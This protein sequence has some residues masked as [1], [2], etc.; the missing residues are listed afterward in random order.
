M[1]ADGYLVRRFPLIWR[2]RVTSRSF[3]LL[4]GVIYL[5]LGICG[6]IPGLCRVH[7]S[8]DVTIAM[9]T[10]M[11]TPLLFGSMPVS[12]ALNVLNILLGVAGLV[13]ARSVLR[14]EKYAAVMAG[15]C[16]TLVVI[17]ILP[18]DLRTFWGFLP[19]TGWNIG[20]HIITAVIAFYFGFVINFVPA[21]EPI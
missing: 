18:F 2:I 4:F 5:V 13:S 14:S 21:S 9:G 12:W 15:L 6:F 3:A 10:E 7:F 11:A 17:G 20:L 16:G 19:L 1:I 8:T